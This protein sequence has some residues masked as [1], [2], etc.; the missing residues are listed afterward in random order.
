MTAHQKLHNAI[1]LGALLHDIGKF[2]QSGRNLQKTEEKHTLRSDM[3]G[4]YH[5]TEKV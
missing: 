5:L 2:K 4:F 3:T 1:I